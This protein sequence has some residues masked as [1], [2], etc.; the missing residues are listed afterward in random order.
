VAELKLTLDKAVYE[1]GE[2]VRIHFASAAR[3]EVVAWQFNRCDNDRGCGCGWIEGMSEGE[4]VIN[5]PT[6]TGKIVLI[7]IAKN[8]F[9]GYSSR[10][11]PLEVREKQG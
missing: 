4:R 6:A 5:A 11:I 3:D 2:E 9:G 10:R 1:Y 7:V 8:A